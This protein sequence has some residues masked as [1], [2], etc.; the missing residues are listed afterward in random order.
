MKIKKSIY[1]NIFPGSHNITIDI[2]Q[3]PFI[4][5]FKKGLDQSS[6]SMELKKC[7]LMQKGSKSIN[8]LQ[9]GAI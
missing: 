3:L 2:Q 4:T 1:Y 9:N 8:P 5:E 6:R 7:S